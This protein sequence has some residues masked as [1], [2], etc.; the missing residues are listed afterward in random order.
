MQKIIKVMLL[1]CIS[2]FLFC[3]IIGLKTVN[4]SIVNLIFNFI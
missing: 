1:H 3:V 2:K 4:Q